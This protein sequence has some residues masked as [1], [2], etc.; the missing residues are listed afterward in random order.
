[1][2]R[3]R[4][5]YLVTRCL[6][7]GLLQ[8]APPIAA[9]ACGAG[10]PDPSRRP[11]GGGRVIG[12]PLAAAAI[13]G[14]APAQARRSVSSPRRNRW[15]RTPAV[16]RPLAGYSVYGVTFTEPGCVPGRAVDDPA[17]LTTTESRPAL[18]APKKITRAP[19][20]SRMPAIPPPPRPCGR[21]EPA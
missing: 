21:T 3:S 13:A 8:T 5:T 10:V 1:M 19:E 4:A 2:P 15:Q 14:A 17:T 16:A 18:A 11:V 9:M 7:A 12:T 6:P 20:P